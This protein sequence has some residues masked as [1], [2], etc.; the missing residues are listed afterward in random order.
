MMKVRTLLKDA[1]HICAICNDR[2]DDPIQ[3]M[4]L[5]ADEDAIFLAFLERIAAN[6]PKVLAS[7]RNHQVNEDPK[8]I[9]FTFG[10]NVG[11]LLYF[12]DRDRVV[13]IC[14][15]FRKRGGKSGATPRDKVKDAAQ[16]YRE[17]FALKESGKIQLVE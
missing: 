4:G 2:G 5:S 17:Y 6:G 13:V 3:Q 8:I 7:N 10:G 16:A 9:Q 1:W 11:R 14:N 15:A 12:Y